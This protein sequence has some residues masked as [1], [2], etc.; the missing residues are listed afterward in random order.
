[1]KQA[2]LLTVVGL[3]ALPVLAKEIVVDAS[4]KAKGSVPTIQKGIAAAAPGDTVLVKGGVYAERLSID[5]D[6]GSSPL[7][8]KAAPGERVIVSGFVPI[9]GWKELGKGVFVATAD[10]TV[11]DLFVGYQP[12]QCARWPEDGTRLPILTA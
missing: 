6:Y 9:T 1:M 12:Q 8:V 4:G 10:E 11:K 5:K 2:C 3:A 7:T